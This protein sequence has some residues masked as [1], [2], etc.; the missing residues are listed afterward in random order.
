M[1]SSCEAEASYRRRIEWP[2]RRQAGPIAMCESAR[3]RQMWR[4]GGDALANA[5]TPHTP[6][7]MQDRGRW[8]VVGAYEG[9]VAQKGR[10]AL[11]SHVSKDVPARN[12][13]NS[14]RVLCIMRHAYSHGTHDR[15]GGA[16]RLSERLEA[17]S[18]RVHVAAHSRSRNTKRSRGVPR[19][20][21]A[22]QPWL[23]PERTSRTCKT[24]STKA[25]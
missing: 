18:D 21:A 22:D 23:R 4:G 7:D 2:H 10:V 6:S 19:T 16:V 15:R 3:S 17:S 12:P 25:N 8:V 24:E 11:S 13:A 5:C 14:P 9:H 20:A 1:L